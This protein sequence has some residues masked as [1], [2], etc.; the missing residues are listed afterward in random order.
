[1]GQSFRPFV[2]GSLAL[3]A[4]GLCGGAPSID[5]V[6]K[7]WLGGNDG[8]VWSSEANW[9]GGIPVNGDILQFSGSSIE[10]AND[11]SDIQISKIVFSTEAASFS[12]T[13]NTVTFSD[14]SG[15]KTIENNATETQTVGFTG[16]LIGL[17]HVSAKSGTLI[18]NS[19]ITNG[20]APLNVDGGASV[21]FNRPLLG[22][23]SLIVSQV[24]EVWFNAAV[25]TAV[26]V[27]LGTVVINS[28]TQLPEA[29]LFDEGVLKLSSDVTMAGVVYLV[30]DGFTLSTAPIINTNGFDLEIRGGI[31]DG[32][33]DLEP[34]DFTKTGLGVLTVSGDNTTDGWS[35][36]TRIEQGTVRAGSATAFR[37]DTAFSLA[38]TSGVTLDLNGKDF[39][40]S[41]L[42]GGG[43]SGGTVNIEG[44]TLTLNAVR[45]SSF[46]GALVG[47]GSLTKT[48]GETFSL[49]GANTYTGGTTVSSGTLRGNAL[50]LQGNI[51]NNA[52]VIFDQTGSGLYAGNLSGTGSLEKR[53]AG[54]LTLSGTNSFSGGTTLTEGTLAVG[55]N[56]ALG[57]GSFLLSGGTLQTDGVNRSIVV[58]GD[59]TQTAGTL[60]LTLYGPGTNHDRLDVSGAMNR[61]GSLHVT[62]DSLYLP[63]GTSTYSLINA[64]TINAGDSFGFFT[65]GA[66]LEFQL[67]YTPTEGVLTA[68][69]T[70]YAS[71]VPSPNQQSVGNYLDSLYPTATGDLGLVMGKLNILPAQDLSTA[72]KSISPQ[73]YQMVTT[74]GSA[75]LFGFSQTLHNQLHLARSGQSGIRA[76]GYDQGQSF[77]R[78]GPLTAEAGSPDYR[79]GYEDPTLTIETKWGAFITG[80]GMYGVVKAGEDL[81]NGNQVSGG[82]TTGVDYRLS[83][84]WI[85][86]LGVGYA[87]SEA[88][89]GS[90]DFS[91]DG[92]SL[93]PGIYG[94]FTQDSYYVDGVL[95]FQ[96][97]DYSA[98]RKIVVGTD[99]RQAEGS[100]DGQAMAVGVEAGRP[101]KKGGWDWVPVGGIQLSKQTVDAFNETGAGSLS[102]AVHETV[103]N[104]FSTHLGARFQRQLSQD[105]RD[106]LELRTAWRHEFVDPSNLNASFAGSTGS[107]SVEPTGSSDSILFGVDFSASLTDHF[108]FLISYDGDLS[109]DLVSRVHGGV[110]VRF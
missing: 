50:G 75:N 36:G 83:P 110:R 42:N 28:D 60:A 62:V 90:E 49:T 109:E 44:S 65:N 107:F 97:S 21:I 78:W 30:D 12:L 35:G 85:V 29:S 95:A 7:V 10:S 18:I 106:R 58:A 8:G 6:D 24:N 52:S 51:L 2:V 66:S 103:Q 20:G 93:T 69:K 3:F 64:G 76:F 89:L 14:T 68:I 91:V 108:S 100:P 15:L 54:L 53:G 88:E 1:M 17:E 47:A 94:S 45:S 46:G 71:H 48:G 77:S 67:D 92:Q 27:A 102:L 41:E 98:T 104:S 31:K 37:A 70:P 4:S 82:F 34:A 80:D 5:S 81:P 61:G 63:V 59:Y 43:S 32:G 99:V 79:Y 26:S 84:Q 11:F 96:S 74:L 55:S 57:M 40:L 39:T 13:G 23:T 16:P 19:T 38:D 33:S 87:L 72:L 73:P 9:D 56:G 86:G 101:F 22:L 105:S 25:S